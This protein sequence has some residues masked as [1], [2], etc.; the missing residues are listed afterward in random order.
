VTKPILATWFASGIEHTM[1]ARARCLSAAPPACSSPAL[2]TFSPEVTGT[3]STGGT[4]RTGTPCSSHP[5]QVDRPLHESEV[6]GKQH[7]YDILCRDDS[8]RFGV[9]SC[10]SMVK[11]QHGALGPPSP[12]CSVAVNQ[13]AGPFGELA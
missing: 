1:S 13:L 4:W 12:L 5:H 10:G 6:Q 7:G 11:K 3:S 2:Q 9:S 8:H